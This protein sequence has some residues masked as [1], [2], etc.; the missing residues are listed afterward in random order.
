MVNS[1][2]ILFAEVESRTT[3]VHLTNSMLFSVE[4]SLARLKAKVE[5]TGADSN[6]AE[7]K[8]GGT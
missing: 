1:D 2:H 8:Q 7:P 6:E 4:E 3:T 5:G